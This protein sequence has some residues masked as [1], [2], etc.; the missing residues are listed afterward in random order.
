VAAPVSNGAAT[1]ALFR[2]EFTG[3][4][5]EVYVYKALDKATALK[6][7]RKD[8]KKIS[9]DYQERG[10]TVESDDSVLPSIEKALCAV[11]GWP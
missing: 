2:P 8:L 3:R 11:P 5:D 1:L 10:I 7:L 4:V 9:R 6:I